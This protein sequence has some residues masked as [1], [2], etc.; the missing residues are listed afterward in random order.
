[1]RGIGNAFGSLHARLGHRPRSF[2]AWWGSALA[3]CLPRRWRVLLGLT[4][5][6]L[7]FQ[8]DGDEITVSWTEGGRRH[9]L[10]RL[11]TSITIVELNTLLRHRL[12][13][14]PRW[15]LVPSAMVLR[16]RLLLP[17]AAANRL[18]DVVRF[19]LDRQ[20]P[21]NV[22]EA[23][24]DA[25]VLSVRAEGQLDIE[26]V[27]APKEA[28]TTALAELGEVGHQLSGADIED[29]SGLTTGINLLPGNV[30]VRPQTARS[31]MPL[32]FA[33]LSIAALLLGA[34]QVLDNRRAAADAFAAQVERSADQ[35]RRAAVDRQQLVDL[36]D[37]IT[38]LNAFSAQRPTA[39]EVL[40]EVT[41]RLPDST[42]LEKLAIEGGRLTLI[43]FSPEASALVGRL[44]GSKLWRNPALSGALQPDPRAHMDR[45][46][47]TAELPGRREPA[48]D[49]AN[50][51]ADATGRH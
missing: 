32:A 26:L 10:A 6:R 13:G 22:Q 3:S 19:E 12:A 41:Q 4:G 39:L 51:G 17:A 16:R 46:T 36:V 8:R 38:T 20:T 37:G 34:W 45:F 31:A 5:E 7:L 35:A 42:Y 47:L 23:C 25:R 1:M 21:F 44:Q 50:G 48:T 40:A 15:W 24:F 29:T 18:R 14:L 30:G 11:P 2:L 27:V 9:Q 49:G 28:L 33:A 43:G